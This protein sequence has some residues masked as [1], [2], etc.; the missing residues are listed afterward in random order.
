MTANGPRIID[1]FGT[2]R[3]DAALD[4]GRCHL[5]LSELIYAPEDINPE[6]PRA[7]NAAVQSEYARLAGTSQAALT[8]AMERCMPILR[9]FALGDR[10][11][12][13]AK[14][15]RLMRSVEATLRLEHE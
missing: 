11:T 5:H 9:A 7:L 3:A 14:R 4:L 13:P 8:A 10:A 15:E 12:N 2:V 6:R 1:W